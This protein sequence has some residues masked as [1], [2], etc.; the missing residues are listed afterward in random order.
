MATP[1]RVLILE[2]R[3]A[4]AELMVH[5]LRQAGFDPAWQRVDNEADYQAHLDPALDV[6]L[7][8]YSLPQWDAPRALRALQDRG[9]D[10]PFIMISGTVGEDVA[11]EC[12]KQ[13]A[14]DYL[15]KDRL[16]R[17]GPAVV[18]ALEDQR[19]R[20]E[21]QQAAEALIASETRYRRLFEAAKDG[22]LILDADTGQVLNVNPFLLDLLGYSEEDLLGKKLWEI[23]LLRDIMASQ[24]AFLDLQHQGYT[25]YENLPL[26]SR[27]GRA[28]KVE[29]VSNAYMV[30]DKQVIQ[31]NIRDI[32]ERKRAEEALH[33]ERD[34]AQ[35]YLDVA[36]V[37]MLALDAHGTITLINQRGCQVLGYEE[38]EL[39]GQNW[40]ETY[41]PESV[42]E[43]VVGV[44]EQLK[45][46]ESGPGKYHENPVLTRTGEERLIAWYNTLLP[47]EAGR[48][49]GT[50]SSGEDI[51]ERKRAEEA[52]A[53]ERNLL[54]TLIDNLPDLIYAK[55]TEGRFIL[56]NQAT[57]RRMGVAAPDEL[58]GHTDLE[59]YPSEV[60]EQYRRDENSVIRSGE[61]IIDNEEPLVN[62]STHTT[63]WQ[64]TSKIPLRRP[65][66]EIIGLVGVGHDITRRKQANEVLELRANQL[67]LLHQVGTATATILDPDEL[68]KRTAELVQEAFG[69][70]HIGLFLLSDD[71]Q[72]VV[73]MARAG[74]YADQFPADHRLKMG[75]GM[76]GCVAEHGE[77]LLANDVTAEPRFRQPA[78]EMDIGS[79]ISMPIIVGQKVIGVI[80]VQSQQTDAFDENDVLVLET[81]A[82]QLASALYNAHLFA[83]RRAQQLLAEALR[84]TG[85]E[86]ARSLDPDQVMNQI[87]EHVGRVVPHDA[88]NIMLIQDG[89]A[90]ITYWRGYTADYE[91]FFQTYRFTLESSNLQGMITT[92]T[93]YLIADTATFADWVQRPETA[94]TRS[95]VAAPLLVQGEVIGFLNLD[96]QTPGF[97]NEGH[98]QRLQAFANL[99]AVSL[100]NARLYEQSQRQAGYLKAL[101]QASRRVSRWG[102]DLDGVLQAIVTSL[103]EEV[104]GAFARIWLSD[105]T[106]ELLILRASAGLYTRLDGEYAR[107]RLDDPNQKVAHIARTGESLVVNH[108]Q[109]NELF[110]Q[111]WLAEQDLQGFAGYPLKITDRIAAVLV[112]FSRQPLDGIVVDVMGSFANQAA[113]AIQNARLYQQLELHS[114]QLEQAVAE[115]TEALNRAR[116]RVEAILNSS[117]DSIIFLEPDTAIGQVN[118]AFYQMFG[119]AIDEVT[120]RPFNTLV[121][122]K[123]RLQLSEAVTTTLAGSQ[124]ARIETVALRQEGTAFDVDIALSP[125][126]GSG[127]L[128]GLVCSIRDITERK[129]VEVVLRQT[130]EK[131]RELGDLKSRFISMASHEFRT[132]LTTITSS[133]YLLRHKQARM[134]AE[135]ITRHFN[136]IEAAV[137]NMTQLLEDVLLIGKV[138]AGRVEFVPAPI[139]F[140]ALCEDVKAAVSIN[141]PANL[142]VAFSSSGSFAGAVM[143]EKLLRH[144]LTNL[145]SNAIKYSPEGGVVAF[146]VQHVDDTAVIRVADQGIGI[147]VENQARLFETFH[148]A[149]NVGTIQGTG[150]GLAIIKNAIEIHGGTIH[151]ESEE[152][153]GTTF[154]VVLPTNAGKG[155][156][157][158]PHDTGD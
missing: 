146:D 107:V 40:F 109:G 8:D 152:G 46:G 116:E 133:N 23:G 4:D 127:Q 154:T 87:L 38:Q 84:D 6:I 50:L 112:L 110:D 96:S 120:G 44:F 76:V 74:E 80:D 70:Q 151:W 16:A 100:T 14:V 49:V 94:W 11:V 150:L 10:V 43:T 101:N 39:L 92:G 24:A 58:L 81:M 48:I 77:L 63:G 156:V 123:S 28:I 51:T 15:L 98:A 95:H 124:P 29:F 144:I 62:L 86:L 47:D 3:P 99:A 149:N 106:G 78:V 102:L 68:L 73:M 121:Q 41:L 75:Q 139:D 136:Q 91:E 115:R 131:E 12:M 134:T 36:G 59:Y 66:G 79:E 153:V 155:D 71:E 2:D 26:E 56:A 25:R 111:A 7:A 64:L 137:K 17:L 117:S 54:R 61:P 9:F 27:D 65:D 5:E 132:P 142:E 72:A 93:S 37:I 85:A 21:K 145:L 119:F 104:G 148:R 90:H 69:Y 108:F 35:R 32:T 125:V 45:A 13:G 135:Q 1:L 114:G 128:I 57:A 60:A 33:Q 126:V 52:L 113:I 83:E 88:A 143:D 53:G 67:V 140:L 118:P 147:P 19:L 22:I 20:L 105:E 138:E 31:C 130:L 34:R 55:D 30:N 42:R 89:Y 158:D 18:K 141:L 82:D 97:F 103:V 157:N 129:Q 122:E